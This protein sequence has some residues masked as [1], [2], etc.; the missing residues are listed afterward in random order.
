MDASGEERPVSL[1]LSTVIHADLGV[2]DTSVET[3]LRIR[4]VLLISEAACWTSSHFF[5]SKNIN[6]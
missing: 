6:N 3:R 2:G 4:L 1:L 5:S